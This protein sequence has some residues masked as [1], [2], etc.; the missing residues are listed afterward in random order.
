MHSNT[1]FKTGESAG[2]V[3]TALCGESEGRGF[4]PVQQIFFH[5]TF[6]GQGLNTHCSNIKNIKFLLLIFL[7]FFFIMLH[8]S[9]ATIS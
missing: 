8:Q 6:I 1:H 2:I 7:L 4:E 5:Y 3:N 9:E